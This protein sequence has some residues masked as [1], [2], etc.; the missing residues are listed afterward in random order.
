MESMNIGKHIASGQ[1]VNLQPSRPGTR[2]P[3]DQGYTGQVRPG[4][5]L[6]FDA[7][8]SGP[9][10]QDVNLPSPQENQPSPIEMLRTLLDRKKEQ[11]NGQQ[12]EQQSE[13]SDPAVTETP[14]V[15]GGVFK[16]LNPGESAAIGEPAY[17]RTSGT[18]GSLDGI[19]ET[20]AKISAAFAS[21]RASLG[22]PDAI[23]AR[24]GRSEDE[25]LEALY[26]QVADERRQ[27]KRDEVDDKRR[28]ARH[29]L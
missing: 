15:E 26:A 7:G 16:L 22:I 9:I 28:R 20:A 8:Y 11:Q 18:P 13:E 27:A 1:Q 19:R 17:E 25:I 6:P 23:G 2:L 5:Y 21:H 14:G 10:R 3:F 24:L 4:T 29:G 12:G